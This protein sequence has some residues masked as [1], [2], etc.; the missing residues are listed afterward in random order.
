MKF[1]FSFLINILCFIFLAG[2]NKSQ[3]VAVF[4]APGEVMYTKENRPDVP[5]VSD[6]PMLDSISQYGITWRFARKMPVGRFV[7]GDYYVVGPAEVISITPGPEGGR[8]GSMLNGPTSVQSGYDSRT[9]AYDANLAIKPPVKLKTGY[10]LISSISLKD[11]EMDRPPVM[12]RNGIPQTNLKSAAVLTC[13]ASPVPPDAFR[14][15]YSD[16]TNTIYRASDLRREVLPSLERVPGTPDLKTWERIF[17]R[18]WIDHTRGWGNRQTHPTDNMPEYGRETSR[19][20]SIVSLMLMVD[21]TPAEK[22]KL[23][24]SFV[25]YGI[26][27][28]GAARHGG[29]WHAEGGYG[30]GRKWPIILAGILLGD[31]KMQTPNISVPGIRFGEDDQTMYGNGWTG[32]KA[33]FAGHTGKNGEGD[34]GPYE[35]LPPAEWPGPKK[36]QSEAYRRCCTSISWVGSALAAHLIDARARWNHDAYFDYVDRWMNE[37]DSVFLVEIQKQTGSD[38]SGQPQRQT[39][40]KFV[41]EMWAKYRNHIPKN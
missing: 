36:T 4:R 21:F 19:A 38:L 23:L 41:D 9:I 2:C 37:D 24:L 27:L 13:L 34:R 6:L 31:E 10:S 22:E 16:T 5:K 17:E 8:N 40:D 20:V 33:I 12:P 3:H 28:W 1:T 26:D 30:N 35:H 14:P 15:S 7:T 32:A 39:W 18:P 11:D 25:Q 29:G